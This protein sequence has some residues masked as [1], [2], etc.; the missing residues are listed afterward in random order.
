MR[1]ETEKKSKH[2]GQVFTPDFIVD[3]MLD[4]CSYFG[5][6][7]I[8]KHVIDNSCGD[9]AF[10]RAVVSR[11]CKV[12]IDSGIDKSEIA[13]QLSKY[14]HGIDTD[15]VA[16]SACLANLT[17]VAAD[18]GIEGVKWDLYNQS[19]LSMTK[20]H[21]KMDYV[22]GNPPYVRVHNLDATYD[23]VKKYKFAN[24]GMTDL[25]LAFFE[26][27]FNMLNPHGKLCY[28][29]PSS[30]LNS[31]AALNM[32]QYMLRTKNLVSLTDLGHFQPFAHAT[33][34]TIISLFSK[35]K[36]DSSFDYFTFDGKTYGRNFVESLKLEDCYIDTYFYLSTSAH[37]ADLR[38]MKDSKAKKYVSVKNGFA[39]LADGVFIGDD[40]P[41]SKITIRTLKASTGKWY[42]C[43]YPYNK[44]GKPLSKD[45]VFAEKAVREHFEANKEELLKGRPEFPGW[46]EFGRTQALLDVWRDKLAINCLCRQP[47]D[48]KIELVK[49]GEGLYSGL[50]IITDYDI[51]FD[52]IKNILV[53]DDFI[54]YVKLLKKYKSGGYYTYN[55][56][57]VEQYLNYF[58]T[59]NTDKDYV[60]KSAVSQQDLTLF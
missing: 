60:N 40:I 44:K 43:L 22:V 25:Y 53:S 49:A 59:Y 36:C 46:W 41:D 34:Y 13:K 5:T 27:G 31:V 1:K 24:G 54:E 18:Y 14:V 3:S 57:D 15:E 58:L 12:A 17:A 50:Y 7:I 20:F 19:S 48:L 37:L 9:G 26:L 56:K 42:K 6:D 11:Y 38:R 30:W 23:E 28:I 39:T 45:E 51:P 10:L 52:E 33:A 8:K 29:T 35:E 47:K 32:R 21:G 16:Y 55:S 2:I 4:Y